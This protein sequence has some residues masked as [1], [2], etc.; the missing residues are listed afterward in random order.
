MQKTGQFTLP[1]PLAESEAANHTQS[2]RATERPYGIDFGIR[3]PFGNAI[4]IG[5]MFNQNGA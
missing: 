5:Q 3:D 1:S 2:R 4:R